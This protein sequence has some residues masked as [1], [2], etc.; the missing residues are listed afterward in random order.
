M[1][2]DVVNAFNLG[3]W[4]KQQGTE[5]PATA[6]Q[7]FVTKIKERMLESNPIGS[8]HLGITLTEE[9]INHSVTYIAKIALLG[10][11]ASD[12]FAVDE[13]FKGDLMKNLNSKYVGN[14]IESVKNDDILKTFHKM[15]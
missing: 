9:H 10:F 6:H 13:I 5:D 12:V 1:N 4:L 15:S 2:Q 14:A 11:I 8:D 3:V 7:F